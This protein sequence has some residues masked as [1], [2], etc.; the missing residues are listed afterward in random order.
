MPIHKIIQ[1]AEG[2]SYYCNYA[3]SVTPGKYSIDWARVTCKNCLRMQRKNIKAALE[4]IEKRKR[5]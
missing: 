2:E 5:K 3:C 1:R 4:L